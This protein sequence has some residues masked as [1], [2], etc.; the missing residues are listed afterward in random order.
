MMLL[1]E[2]LDRP[3]DAP[4]ILCRPGSYAEDQRAMLIRDVLAMANLD[5]PGSRWILV[6]VEPGLTR[7]QVRGIDSEAANR[8]QEFVR[9]LL[10][11]VEPSLT[12]APVFAELDGHRLAAIEISGCDNPPYVTREKVAADMR[13][14]ACWIRDGAD[15]RPARRQDLERIYSRREKGVTPPVRIGFGENADNE[16][17]EVE[18]PDT[19]CPPSLRAREQIRLAM[20]ARKSAQKILGRED[21]GMARLAHARIFGA[22]MPFIRRG[23]DTLVENY[24]H[25][26][27]DYR[28]ADR[29]YYL[30]Q[31]AVKLN[32][33]LRVGDLGSLQN[34]AVDFS[35][36]QTAG[37]EVADRI[38]SDPDSDQ[39]DV[40]NRLLG[41]PNVTRT[42]E[43][44]TFRI[45]L[46]NLGAS[47]SCTLLDTPLRIAVGRELRGRKVAIRYL[48]TADNLPQP[49]HG[50]LKLVF[51]R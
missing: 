28:D 46:G 41:Y 43:S 3:A 34:V 47:E 12:V 5:Y 45:E 13:T 1:E 27:D 24:N 32:F 40:E 51:C 33:T 30:E 10:P 15:V 9:D 36:P 29:H 19:S 49:L 16:Q 18:I 23:M 48:L 39:S 21:T 8:L 44:A 26:A 2:L 17:L 14:G 35:L 31:R 20:D 50:R 7:P 11:Q 38:V 25:I 37:F 4:E 6:G 22:D 42:R